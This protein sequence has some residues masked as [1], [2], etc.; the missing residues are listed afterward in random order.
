MEEV[1]AVASIQIRSFGFAPHTSQLGLLSWVRQLVPIL[2]CIAQVAVMHV[3]AEGIVDSN[4]WS[5]SWT[6]FAFF[7]APST[8]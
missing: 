8:L 4:R 2:I 1:L 3:R 7:T 6:L 5:H